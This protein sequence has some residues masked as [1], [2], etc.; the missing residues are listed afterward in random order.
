MPNR[1]ELVQQHPQHPALAG[2]ARD[3][4][5]DP[6][7]GPL[8]VAVNPAHPLLQPR[9]VP[10]DVVVDH[11]PAELQVD[12]L[13]GRV[14]GDHVAGAVRP[15]EGR[16]LALPFPPVHAAV[17]LRGMAPVAKPFQAPHQV[18]HGVPVFAEDEPLLVLPFGILQ[19]L[20]ELLELGFRPR[21]DQPAR[22]LR[23]V[24]DLRRLSAQLL[25]ADHGDRAEDGVL[26]GLVALGPA[27]G[28]RVVVRGCGVEVVLAV[29][30]AQAPLP[31]EQQLGGE[32]AAL[33]R[34]GRARELLDAPLEGAVQGPG[35]AGEPA[36]EHGP[37]EF[38][39][40]PVV[41]GAAVALVEVAGG[42]F[43]EVLLAVLA[44]AQAVAEGVAPSGRVERATVEA[45]HLLLRAAEEVPVAR[46]PG[47]AADGL[48][49]AEGVGVEQP[50]QPGPGKAL[51][52]VRR[53]G[54]Q[55]EMAGRPAET[56]E[57]ALRAGADGERLRELVAAGPVDAAA[58]LPDAEL[59]RLVEHD[60]VVAAAGPSENVEHP[61]AGQR[62]QRH[63]RAL[64]AGA[65]ER[66]PRS[67]VG[68]GDDAEVQSKQVPQL[69]PPVADQARGRNDQHALQAL[70][71]HHLA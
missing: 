26:V 34:L 31:P 66:I 23:Q 63:D 8:A 13:A 36:L 19:H 46:G 67:R 68:A 35:R 32:F 9:R 2:A 55:Q 53:G 10:G 51:P 50:P 43:V 1:L 39:R 20:A 60:E 49:R 37:G 38:D 54:E 40:G 56:A 4:I 62:V 21:G 27:V 44:F 16:R 22:P 33:D 18:V 45:G 30:L 48:R 57:P 28:G 65:E 58:P 42:P 15:P 64:A 12:A 71:R 52:H 11:Q 29:P 24:L 5:E 25:R 69:P 7:F 41:Q 61:V 17:D 47:S 70:P 14:G 3:E 6:H 59:V